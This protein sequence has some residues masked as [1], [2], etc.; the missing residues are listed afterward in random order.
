M[1]VFLAANHEQYCGNASMERYPVAVCDPKKE[2]K[3]L[4]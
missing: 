4:A 2:T 1:F 3:L